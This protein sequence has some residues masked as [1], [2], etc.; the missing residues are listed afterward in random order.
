VISDLDPRVIRRLA[1]M[2]AVYRMFGHAGELLYIGKTGHLHR[3]DDHAVKRWF[4]AVSRIALEWYET[5]A[6][7]RVAERRAIQTERP[8]YNIASTSK[9]RRLRE[10]APKAP[11]PAREQPDG[12]VLADVLH[13]FGDARG[14]QWQT[15]AE[16]LAEHFPSRWYDATKEV[17]S[18]QC[19]ALGVRTITVR[20]P[21]GSHAAGCV[22]QG[23]HRSDVEAAAARRAVAYQGRDSSTG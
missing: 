6:A 5:E 15:L 1:D 12:D 20:W 18:A 10:S 4:P 9:R 23:C 13:V 19:R 21:L 14:L 7:A 11:A 22:R 8:R 3:F 17:V 2:H 16:R